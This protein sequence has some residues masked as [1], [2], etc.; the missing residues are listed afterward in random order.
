MYKFLAYN[1]LLHTTI[2]I[3]GE[4]VSEQVGGEVSVNNDKT[5]ENCDPTKLP[6]QSIGYDCGVI[7]KI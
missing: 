3:S 4:L 5:H 7:G 6:N 2:G 1:A